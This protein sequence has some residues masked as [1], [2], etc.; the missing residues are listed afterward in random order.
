MIDKIYCADVRPELEGKRVKLAGWVYRKREVGK[1]VFIVLRDS[2]GIVQV[3]FSKDLSEEAYREAKKLGIES[4]V[5]IEGTVKADPRAPTGAEVQADKLEVIQN[6]E[7]F[8]ITKDASQEF[9]L[10]VRHLHLRSPKVAVIMKVKATL[11]QA[12][13]EWLLQDG[14]YEVF[15][16]ILVTGAV[17]GGATLFK[18]KYFDKTAYLSQSAQLYLEAAIFGLEKVWSLTPSFRAEKSRT[19]RHLTEFWHLELEAA[20]MD[21]WDIMKVEEELVSY[22]VQRTLELRRSEIEL[23]RKDDIKTLK[24]TVPPFPR[25]SYDEAIEVLQSKG[26]NIEWGD[27]MGADEERVL[28]EEF[29][30]P[31]F[32]YGYPKHIKAF[33]MKEDPSDP[34]KVLAADMLA[35]EGYGEIIGGSQREDDYDKLVQRI[36][37]EGMKPEDYQWY[38][39]LRKY[40]SVPHSGFGLGLERL[41]AWVLKLD[42][43]RW[44]TLFPRT[45]SRLYP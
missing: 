9:L 35:P 30:S 11:M 31:F 38:L 15:P 24:N 19:R 43:V 29:E 21:L 39:D 4:S 20:W 23:Y 3:V 8:P 17:E 12:A 32:V 27:D 13:R 42:H 45:P 16:P 7:F 34:R 18:L 28:T 6:V 41:V 26:V 37:E 25:I 36:L 14:W 33:Y 5:I 40:G 44:A 2:S 22:M 1:K 10:D